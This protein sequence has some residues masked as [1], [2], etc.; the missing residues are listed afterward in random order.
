MKLIKVSISAILCISCLSA[1]FSVDRDLHSEAT[2]LIN[3][4]YH[5]HLEQWVQI[6]KLYEHVAGNPTATDDQIISL[7]FQARDQY[8]KVE[9]LLYEFE[10]TYIKKHLNGAPL[11]GLLTS[12]DGPIVLA[13]EGLQ[14]LDEMLVEP[15]FD[16][17]EVLE[18]VEKLN[19]R[20]KELI[21]QESK[22]KFEAHHVIDAMRKNLI[23]VM[24][25]GISGFD[26]P[27]FLRS[28]PE[29]IISLQTMEED[30]RNLGKDLDESQMNYY[31][32]CIVYFQGA[33]EIMGETA[34]FNNLDRASLTRDYLNPLYEEL[35]KF[36]Q[37]MGFYISKAEARQFEA[38]NI[39]STNLFDPD[40]LNPYFYTYLLEKDDN[41]FLQELG[42]NL[43]FDPILSS[44]GKLS[45][46]SC[47]QPEK[48]FTDGYPTSLTN[49]AN[50]FGQR[51]T[52]TLINAI[53]SDR[54]FY[55]L[56]ADNPNEQIV[57]VF[58]NPLEFNSGFDEVARRLQQSDVYVDLFANAYPS[59]NNENLIH[60]WTISTA[61]VSY[62]IHL[63]SYNSNFEKYMRKEIDQINPAILEGYNIFMGKAACGTCHFP[64]NFSGLVP[65]DFDENESE[66]LGVP[67]DS[68]TKELD[69]DPGR[70][71]N[72][73]KIEQVDHF[74]HS[75]KTV[76]LRNVA[77]TTPYMHN[78]I[79][80]T[81]EEVID[82]YNKG[83]GS[84]AG[85]KVPHQ[86]LSEV[87]LELSESEK[88]NLIIFLNALTDTS[89]NIIVPDNLPE[90][91]T[92][93]EFETFDR[94][95]V[96]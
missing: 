86:T 5:N 40:L 85:F 45:C 43:F 76:S 2:E 24:T 89:L 23:R 6:L 60:Q 30:F 41:T 75:F 11:P 59:M 25:L 69:E 79:Y 78:G 29:S 94:K 12:D 71:G 51:N 16:R 31:N 77:L 38:W 17:K 13:P 36:H 67:K 68:I 42:Q 61:L 21:L 90:F 15:N 95:P 64:P 10:S 49:K 82:F 92:G 3:K 27:G 28:I 53:Y 91:R 83:G 19:S 58:E 14:T 48:S 9:Y 57:H 66:V 32:N 73:W 8:K 88:S 72:K 63:K 39:Y 37:Q 50:T 81:L 46:A 96:Y 4:R 22:R 33:V 70:F 18:L 62:V 84:G 74:K 80:N 56:R 65:P 93:S 34:D 55:D 1:F 44:D 54:Y 52:P 87:P 26:S 47:H 7:H 35:W 20:A